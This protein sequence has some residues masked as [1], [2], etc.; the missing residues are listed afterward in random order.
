MSKMIITNRDTLDP[1]L[2]RLDSNNR[3]RLFWSKSI[4]PIKEDHNIVED[5]VLI[6][7]SSCSE[8]FCYKNVS[9]YIVE[10]FNGISWDLLSYAGVDISSR[11]VK[12]YAWNN[13]SMIV[14]SIGQF[15]TDTIRWVLPGDTLIIRIRSVDSSGYYSE[16]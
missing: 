8:Y 12:Q 15:V 10:R 7:P 11:Y 14:S 3:V 2:T 1:N 6:I 5:S 13:D 16:L 9:K 4:D